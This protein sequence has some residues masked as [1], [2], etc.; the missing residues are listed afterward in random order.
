MVESLRDRAQAGLDV[1]QALAVG[2][3]REDHREELVPAGEV[4]HPMIAT[5]ALDQAPE[6]VARQVI[7]EL[8]E[9]RASLVH[10]RLLAESSAQARSPRA[11]VQVGDSS[12]ISYPAVDD[13][14]ASSSTYVNRTLLMP[15]VTF[16]PI[17]L[18]GEYSRHD[19][20]EIWGYN[21]VQGLSRGVV[22]ASGTKLIILFVTRDKQESYEPYENRLEQDRLR[23][24][25]PTDHFAESRML[26]AEDTG[27]EIHLFYRERHHS[28]FTYQGRLQ[29]EHV[30]RYA[31]RPSGFVFRLLDRQ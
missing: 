4:A 14:L 18:H 20:A 26:A 13:A 31:D 30:D 29:V 24:E 10:E 27:D 23:W 16:D 6:G 2:Q 17:H 5:I 7:E 3:L 9:H 19:L 25:G 1:A 8:G 12:I 21:G 28:N 15:N 22:T 11:G